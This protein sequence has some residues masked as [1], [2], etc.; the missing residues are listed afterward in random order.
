MRRSFSTKS[1][2]RAR[3]LFT[4]QIIVSIN[5]LARK[6]AR[7]DAIMIDDREFELDACACEHEPS[8]RAKPTRSHEKHPELI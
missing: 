2:R 4:I 6:I 3:H 5:H 8:R 7:L 1:P